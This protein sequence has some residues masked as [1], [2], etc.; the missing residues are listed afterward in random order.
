MLNPEIIQNLT[1][2]SNAAITLGVERVLYV[3]ALLDNPQ[4]LYKTIH[5]TGTNGKGSTA[6]FIAAGLIHAGFRVGKF[7][8]PHV[9]VINEN[10]TLNNYNISDKDLTAA[11]DIV[12]NTINSYTIMLSPFELLTTTMFY[13]FAK[14]GI[15]YLVLEVGL[16][17]LNDATNVVDSIIAIITNVGLEHTQFL[18]DTLAQIAE[19]KAGIIKPNSYVILGSSQ[20]ELLDAVKVKTS[21]YIRV[22]DKYNI[23]VEL[24]IINFK[25]NLVISTSENYLIN[26]N[27]SLNSNL[28]LSLSLFG[29][30]QAYNFLCAY[31]ALKKLKISED[32]IVYAA[33]NTNLPY[34][35]Q[36]ISNRLSIPQIIMD[37][38]HNPDG[39]KELY[40]T[41][42]KMYSFN[43]V[44]IITSILR[45]KNIPKM[46]YYF[47]KLASNIIFTS[48]TNTERALSADQL[49]DIV[50]DINTSYYHSK[51]LL[52]KHNPNYISAHINVVD[53]PR[54]ALEF[55]KKLNKKL[56]IITG[57]FYLLSYFG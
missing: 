50:S 56:I 53:E 57:S 54:L 11:Y 16:G 31:A 29:E 38:T 49:A 55:A 3:L 47:N 7:T 5:I 39:A 41:L 40:Q 1:T 28:S 24:D 27:P 52:P 8:S 37:A 33:S 26:P 34:R 23:K 44:V 45:D 9:C 21:N 51:H 30:F 42:S 10:I 25:T 32:S 36:L 13:Y 22:L 17:G 4:N 20:V 6:A 46:L 2:N 19:Q 14:V 15:D 43:E 18:G 12:K 48:I 35:M